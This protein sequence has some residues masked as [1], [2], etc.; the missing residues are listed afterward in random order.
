MKFSITQIPVRMLRGVGGKENKNTMEEVFARMR[1][2]HGFA[3][4]YDQKKT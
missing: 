2:S 4:C 1:T 3:E